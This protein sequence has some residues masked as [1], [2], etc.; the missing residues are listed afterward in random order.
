MCLSVGVVRCVAVQ[1]TVQLILF[2]CLS[3]IKQISIHTL[4]TGAR[5]RVEC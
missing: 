2:W 5:Y 3:L 4:V 1:D